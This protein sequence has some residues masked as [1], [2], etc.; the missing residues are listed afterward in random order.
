MTHGPVMFD[1]TGTELLPEEQEMLRHPAA[2]GIILFQRNY[3]DPEQLHALIESIHAVRRPGLLV[4]VDQEG[5]RVQRF[6]EGFTRLP[7]ASWFGELYDKHGKDCLPD[8]QKIGWLMAAELRSVGV[9]FSF[10]PVLDIGRGLGTVIGSRAFH[11]RPMVIAELAHA[12]IRGVHEAGMSCVGKHFPGHGGVQEDSHI[13]L[14]VDD[15][16]L[17][18]LLMGDLVPFQRM[19]DHGMEAIMPA[20]VIYS[21]CDSKPAGFSSFWLQQIL[22]ERLGF[23]GVIFS[24]DLNMEGAGEA[25]SYPQRAQA[26]LNAGCD[27][28]LVCNNPGQARKVLNSLANYE[29]PVSQTRLVRMHGHKRFSRSTLHQERRWKEA[30][31]LVGSYDESPTLELDLNTPVSPKQAHTLL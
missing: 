30:I 4:A 6:H 13:E 16:R 9:D 17:E 5:G 8:V 7:P 28:V 2:G 24:D 19:I 12:W 25:G 31:R 15:R 11:N 21:R 27:M 10:A 23:Q 3:Q 18:D 14:P 29:N 20:H 1:L 22:R 26:A